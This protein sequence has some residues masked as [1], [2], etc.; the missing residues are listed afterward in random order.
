MNGAPRSESGQA[1]VELLGA[2]PAL[3][4]VGL[5]VL[6]LLAIGYSKVLAG[7]AAEAGALAMAGGGGGARAGGGPGAGG[8]RGAAA[9][10]RR[11]AR[12]PEDTAPA[13]P[14]RAPRPAVRGGGGV[15]ALGG[16]SGRPAGRVC[17]V[18]DAELLPA[19]VDR[20]MWP[21]VV[22]VAHASHPADGLGAAN[23][24]VLVASPAVES[25]L[26]AAV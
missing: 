5:V 3:L 16:G 17:L 4:V 13:P 7:D 12:G 19:I 2:L 18:R 10:G 24:V 25:S 20:R 14:R 21:V 11:G 22:D 26:V 15:R 23:V 6:Q 8:G 9:G 1:S